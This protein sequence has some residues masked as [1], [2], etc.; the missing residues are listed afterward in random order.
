MS[1][2]DQVAMDSA[3]YEPPRVEKVLSAAELELEA[4]YAGQQSQPP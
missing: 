2:H 1:D 4:L 3:V